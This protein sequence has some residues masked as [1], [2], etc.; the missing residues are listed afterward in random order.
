MGNEISDVAGG[1]IFTDT[2]GTGTKIYLNT[3]TDVTLRAIYN[4]VGTVTWT[5]HLNEFVRCAQAIY[6]QDS[7]TF[8]SDYNRYYQ[9]DVPYRINGTNYA[10]LALYNAATSQ[11]ANGVEE[12]PQAG[13]G[14]YLAGGK[15]YL[16]H[17]MSVVSPDI[18]ARRYFEARDTV[19]T[20]AA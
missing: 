12:A 14:Y 18:G 17:S 2:A 3:F 16:G 9:C 11:D 8:A 19:T 4:T 20:R 15:H 1:V 10:T 5:A 7:I 13:G 6:V